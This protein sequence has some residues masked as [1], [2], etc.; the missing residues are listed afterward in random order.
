[1]AIAEEHKSKQRFPSTQ[2]ITGTIWRPSPYRK[3]DEHVKG[4]VS[5]SV[6]N[7]TSPSFDDYFYSY[8]IQGGFIRSA[9][10]FAS[11]SRIC[12]SIG[13]AYRY[14]ANIGRHHKS[15]GVFFVVDLATRTMIQKCYDPDCKNFAS[16]PISLPVSCFELEPLTD[17][18]LLEAAIKLGF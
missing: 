16:I 8:I 2:N 5:P 15:N 17:E 12:Y 3:L 9:L 10:Y 11:S 14:C 6:R 1:M 13:G 7:Q 4:L 18:E